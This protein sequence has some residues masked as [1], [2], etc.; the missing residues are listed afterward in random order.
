MKK[1][2]Q[3]SLSVVSAKESWGLCLIAN[4]Q[5]KEAVVRLTLSA[6]PPLESTDEEQHHHCL[7]LFDDHPREYGILINPWPILRMRIEKI[8]LPWA[9]L[10]D[11][12]KTQFNQLFLTRGARR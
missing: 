11:E 8:D 5:F 3:Q 4:D 1:Q 9:D 12:S 10:R 2:R 7:P 6:P